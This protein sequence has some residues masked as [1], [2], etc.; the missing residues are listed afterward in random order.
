VP[1]LRNP[2]PLP[3]PPSPR[4]PPSRPP[5]TPSLTGARARGELCGLDSADLTWGLAWPLQLAQLGTPFAC[6]ANAVA[7]R[8]CGRACGSADCFPFLPQLGGE[9]VPAFFADRGV[10]RLTTSTLSTSHV[11]NKHLHYFGF[12]PVVME[13]GVGVGYGVYPSSINA[14]V[15]GRFVPPTDSGAQRL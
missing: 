2:P 8:R 4:P 1:S 5:A 12:G 11:G 3:P 13:D 15:S 6:G 10:A 9:K 7:R 14:V